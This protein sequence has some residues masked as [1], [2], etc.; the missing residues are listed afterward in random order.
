MSGILKVLGAA[1][2]VYVLL[3]WYM[4]SSQNGSTGT[5]AGTAAAPGAAT[6]SP[7][8]KVLTQDL[9]CTKSQD[10]LYRVASAAAQGDIAGV[11]SIFRRDDAFEVKAGTSI[12][13]LRRE[14]NR[15]R[16]WIGS[17]AHY[18]ES[19]WTFESAIR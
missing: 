12:D 6:E 15:R 13:L 11:N 16:I 17:G 8:T 5:A 7:E 1:V 9:I 18:K 19:C 14:D 4:S 2:A 3:V 10:D